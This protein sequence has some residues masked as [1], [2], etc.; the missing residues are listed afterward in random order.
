MSQ[1]R[2]SLGV[3]LGF[4]LLA[5]GSTALAQAIPLIVRGKVTMKDGSAPPKAVGVQPIC[6]DMQGSAPGPL[7]GKSGDYVWRMDVDPMRTR[8]CWLQA[9]LAGYVSTRIEISGLNG[10]TSTTVDL[11]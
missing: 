7:T 3:L 9:E 6:S 5:I 4:G 10:F 2:A 8:R 1:G 11:Q